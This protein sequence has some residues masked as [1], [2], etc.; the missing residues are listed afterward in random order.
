MIAVAY[1][2]K[3]TS[4]YIQVENMRQSAVTTHIPLLKMQ[5][6]QLLKQF[7]VL[8]DQT[9]GHPAGPYQSFPIVRI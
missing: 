7:C 9:Q 6:M 8:D 4:R 3:S 1:H 2:G 5:H